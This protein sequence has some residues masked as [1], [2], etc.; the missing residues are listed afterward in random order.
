[1]PCSDEEAELLHI[2]RVTP[3]LVV[4]GTMYDA[5]G[6][7]VEYGFARLRGDRSQVEITVVAQRS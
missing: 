4:T 7:P 5:E 3:L 2:A 1:V 6:R